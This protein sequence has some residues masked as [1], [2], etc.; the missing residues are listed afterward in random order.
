MVVSWDDDV[1]EGS[2]SAWMATGRSP[3]AEP[4]FSRLQGPCDL[5]MLFCLSVCDETR[6]V[7]LD[8]DW[9]GEV[10]AMVEGRDWKEARDEA[11]T[12]RPMND[13]SYCSG[14]GWIRRRKS[15]ML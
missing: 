6:R 13:F 15:G 4:D 1:L 8:Q 12:L 2:G 14:V 9:Y 11:L 7:T 5:I 10:L 3:F